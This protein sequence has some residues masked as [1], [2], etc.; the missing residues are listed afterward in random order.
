M[1]VGPPGRLGRV[2]GR[3]QELASDC[4]LCGHPA[5]GRRAPSVSIFSPCTKSAAAA[6]PS[7]ALLR[8]VRR[9]RLRVASLPTR[10]TIIAPTRS[11]AVR[12]RAAHLPVDS[13]HTVVEERR[14]PGHR[15][16]TKDASRPP[17]ERSSRG[18]GSRRGPDR[19]PRPSGRARSGH[20]Q[21]RAGWATIEPTWIRTFFT[22]K[23][24]APSAVI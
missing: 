14:L 3:P 10:A 5:G 20:S 12:V 16:R 6:Q 21:V 13:S 11:A 19:C 17:N 24:T 2:G 7:S 18:A 22:Y 15:H 23:K 8:L 9:V 4:S 1:A